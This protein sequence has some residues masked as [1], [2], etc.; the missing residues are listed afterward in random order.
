MA[1]I[2]IMYF[3]FSKQVFS[4][5][6]AILYLLGWWVHGGQGGRLFRPYGIWQHI[7]MAAAQTLASWHQMLSSDKN[8]H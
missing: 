1:K 7:H 5:T 4:H 6:L 2:I 3:V 8:G